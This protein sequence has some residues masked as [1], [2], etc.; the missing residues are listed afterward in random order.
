VGQR[1]VREADGDADF[2]MEENPVDGCSS[3]DI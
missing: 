3:S 2:V 1:S